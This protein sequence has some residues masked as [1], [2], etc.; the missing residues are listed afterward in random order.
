MSKTRYARAALL[1]GACALFIG[2]AQAAVIPGP[3]LNIAGSG[4][5]VTGLEFTALANTTLTG[6]TYQNQG[7][8]DTILLT[9]AVGNILDSVSTP[10]GTPSDTVSVN[11]SLTSGQSYF[12]LQTVASNEL[13]ASY[14]LPLPS[15]S[16][17]SVI[18]S[19][20]FAYS[21]ADAVDN[22]NGWGSN[23]YWAAF[24]DITTSGVPE[25]AAWTMMLAGLCA[26]GAALRHRR[27]APAQA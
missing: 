22:A 17:L 19:G 13:Y 1:G 12:L 7:A 16:D 25:P 3:T 23:Q 5:S 24:N 2:T 4:W 20:T 10:S 21:I 26:L 15:N 6:F 14:G 27:S 9:D 8:A 18:F 11:W